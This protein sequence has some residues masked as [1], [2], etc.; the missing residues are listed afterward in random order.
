MKNLKYIA[1]L[2]LLIACNQH[3]EKADDAEVTGLIQLTSEQLEFNDIRTGPM[4]KGSIYQ[5]VRATGQVDIPP[6]YSIKVSAPIEAYLSQLKVLPGQRVTRGQLLAR[7]KHPSIAEIQKSYLTAFAELN[8]ISKDLARKEELLDGNVVSAREFER[9]QS[10]KQAKTANLKSIRSELERLGI[11]YRDLTSE[12]VSQ[13]L[14]LKAPISG[15]VTDFF[16]QTGQFATPNDPLLTIASRDHEHV[17]LEVFQED[18][19]RVKEGM[20]VLMR[21]PGHDRVY[22]GEIFLTNIQLDKETLAA[23]V[24][25]H[26]EE[27]FPDLPIGA[28][29]FGEIIYQVDSGYVM[30]RSEVIRE[31]TNHFIFTSSHEGYKKQ[32]VEIG[33]DDGVNVNIKGPQEMLGTEVVLKGNY[34]LNG[35]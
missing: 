2:S 11:D 20:A 6:N 24:H 17:E 31:G 14:D 1:V 13:S 28:V 35:I 30:P 4:P 10:E 23:N 18:L 22:T 8:Y 5:K 3:V 9:L 26:V 29:V 21:L 33:F 16:I 12:N 27:D 34:Y 32:Q 19:S 15:V 25:V 7:L